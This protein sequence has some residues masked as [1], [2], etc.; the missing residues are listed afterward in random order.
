MADKYLIEQYRTDKEIAGIVYLYLCKDKI[1]DIQS[2]R[3]VVDMPFD[4]MSLLNNNRVMFGD[5]ETVNIC[6]DNLSIDK[7]HLV[8]L[9]LN[10]KV[11]NLYDIV[12]I[13]DSNGKLIGEIN[14]FDKKAYEKI[15]EWLA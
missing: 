10:K 15:I 3:I 4:A 14:F 11:E 8:L 9:S 13:I 1:Y 5:Y 12:G 2:C 7:S 6:L